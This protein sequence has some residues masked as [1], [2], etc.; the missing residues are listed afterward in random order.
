MEYKVS[1]NAKMS[2]V[3]EAFTDLDS[4]L[5]NRLL[6]FGCGI[7]K[8]KG[9]RRRAKISVYTWFFKTYHFKIAMC[10]STVQQYYFH[11]I[12]EGNLPFGI[13]LWTNRYKIIKT[14]D[15]CEII[16]Q[17]EYT[18]KNITLDKILRV[19]ITMMFQI[20]KLK[21]KVFFLFKKHGE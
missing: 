12:N 20:R 21:Y 7:L 16:N 9:I 17:V 6:P 3:R 10:S 19:F 4:N 11:I 8:F 15:G 1:L 2:T 14:K 5:M 13:K 18:T